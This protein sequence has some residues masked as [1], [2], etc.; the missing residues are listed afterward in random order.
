[1][2]VCTVC[3]K[4]TI[5]VHDKDVREPF[6]YVLHQYNCNIL[7]QPKLRK[8]QQT[9][10][11]VLY[12]IVQVGTPNEAYVPHTYHVLVGNHCSLEHLPQVGTSDTALK[13]IQRDQ[14]A[15]FDKHR[16]ICKRRGDRIH[17][18]L[19]VC[20]CARALF[21]CVVFLSTYVCACGCMC[22]GVDVCAS[23]FV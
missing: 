10:Y 14:V 7:H 19:C 1:M 13:G 17:V 20:V 8:Q 11:N 9:G 3:T 18:C 4:L 16:D 2:Y 23:V 6:I 15:A 12:S 22:L 5:T 21:A